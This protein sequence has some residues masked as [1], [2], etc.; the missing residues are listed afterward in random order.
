MSA[1]KEKEDDRC[2]PGAANGSHCRG[3]PSS[4]PEARRPCHPKHQA[5]ERGCQGPQH[6]LPQDGWCTIPSSASHLAIL[7]SL[8][9]LAG[10]TGPTILAIS[11]MVRW[12]HLRVIG[13]GFTFQKY[14]Y[15]ILL[16][17]RIPM[18]GVCGRWHNP[19]SM[20]AALQK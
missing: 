10:H 20:I 19:Q 4:S 11:A 5:Q 8:P 3:A 17:S 2:L 15:E 18:A 9:E 14:L 7:G 13:I 6:G 1:G 16:E 12:L